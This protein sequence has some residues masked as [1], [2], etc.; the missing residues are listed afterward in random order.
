MR[1]VILPAFV[2]LASPTAMF[3]Q[4]TPF[5]DSAGRFTV[6]VPEGWAVQPLGDQGTLLHGNGVAIRIIP[7]AAVNTVQDAITSLAPQVSREW[8]QLEEV[9]RRDMTALG[10]P[11][12]WIVYDGTD[13]SGTRA[14]IRVMGMR[15]G[16]ATA[17]IVISSERAGYSA[18]RGA[19]EAVLATLRLGTDPPSVV[20]LSPG[21]PSPVPAESSDSSHR[22]AVKQAGLGLR[23]R[24]LTDD[25]VENLDL[26]DD[27]G[28]Y[29]DEVQPRGPADQAGI[30]EGDVII[31]IDRASLANSTDLTRIIAAHK[32]GDTI[33]LTILRESERREVNVRIGEE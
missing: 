18:Q 12:A 17:G 24:D 6:R 32:A 27:S 28:V 25:D 21:R 16:G 13:I 5:A 26:D 23:V 1:L 4:G 30:L 33:S 7:M 8:R 19:I 3:A 15:G 22:P 31:Q 9:D 2:L 14:T 10:Q 11:A 20:G 29:I